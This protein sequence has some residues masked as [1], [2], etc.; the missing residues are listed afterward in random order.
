MTGSND[1]PNIIWFDPIN[2]PVPSEMVN[3][4]DSVSTLAFSPLA[5]SHAGTYT[6]VVS[7]GAVSYNETMMITVNSMCLIL[8][9]WYWYYY[10]HFPDPNITVRVDGDT[11]PPIVGSVYSLTCAVAGTERLTDANVTYQWFRDGV[12]L[13]GQAMETLS[14]SSLTISDAGSYSCAI[15]LSSYLLSGPIN[16]DSDPFHVTLSCKYIIPWSVHGFLIYI[17]IKYWQHN[18]IIVH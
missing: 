10:V 8:H 17:Q 12:V 6:C 16:R 7:L 4:T 13:P 18:I 1:Q 15:V 11:V 5:A 9:Q 2:N 3:T 14:F